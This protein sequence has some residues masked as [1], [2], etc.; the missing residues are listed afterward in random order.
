VRWALEFET[1]APWTRKRIRLETDVDGP[2][3]DAGLSCDLSAAPATSLTEGPVLV[4]FLLPRRLPTPLVP[5]FV[6]CDD[7]A[8][9]VEHPWQEV[10]VVD[11]YNMLG[12]V[13]R[14]DLPAGCLQPDFRF[15]QGEWQAL[16]MNADGTWRRL[17]GSGQHPHAVSRF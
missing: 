15:L 16:Q 2:W 1:Q 7:P 11:L 17:R 10:R 3:C 14:V 8:A 5:A 9:R 13:G 4:Q 12:I 6:P